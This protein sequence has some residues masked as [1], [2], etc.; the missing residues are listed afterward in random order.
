MMVQL[1]ADYLGS[2]DIPWPHRLCAATLRR[3]IVDWVL[4]LGHD[5]PRLSRFGEGADSWLFDGDDDQS[6]QSFASMCDL[7]GLPADMIRD[8]IRAMTGEQVRKL[9]GME[10]GD[11]C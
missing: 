1:D 4:Y 9:R 10:F 5:D 7:L 8:R 6:P 3:A 11:E 2:D